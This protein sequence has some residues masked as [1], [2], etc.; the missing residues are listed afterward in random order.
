MFEPVLAIA[1]GRVAQEP[2]LR[3]NSGV[4]VRAK[5][6]LSEKNDRFIYKNFTLRKVYFLFFKYKNIKQ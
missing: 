6:T 4:P 5:A 2:R 1:D 3:K